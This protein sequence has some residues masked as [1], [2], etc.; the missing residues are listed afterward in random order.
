MFTV[1]GSNSLA[2]HVLLRIVPS[3]FSLYFP[4]C[5]SYAFSLHLVQ[6]KQ[7]C[8]LPFEVGESCAVALDQDA[9]FSLEGAPAEALP[10]T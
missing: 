6:E 8:P 10:A 3:Y 4:K 9:F 7:M 2:V 1:A 5:I